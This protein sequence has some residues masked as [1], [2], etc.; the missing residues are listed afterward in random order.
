MLFKVFVFVLF[1]CIFENFRL[2]VS[3]LISLDW[4]VH[5]GKMVKWRYRRRGPASLVWVSS[6]ISLPA[7]HFLPYF[8]LENGAC[9]KVCLQCKLYRAGETSHTNWGQTLAGLELD[10]QWEHGQK[11]VTVLREEFL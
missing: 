5:L 3:K 9:V 11:F 4:P 2:G 1:V 6:V 10:C 8:Q 7:R